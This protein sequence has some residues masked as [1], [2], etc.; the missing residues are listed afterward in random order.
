MSITVDM[1]RIT[2][3][4]TCARAPCGDRFGRN[5]SATAWCRALKLSDFAIS[6]R[7][8]YPAV[9]HGLVPVCDEVFPHRRKKRRP[10]RRLDVR[11][12]LAIDPN[13]CHLLDEFS[14][15]GTEGFSSFHIFLHTMSPL[16]PR[17]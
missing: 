8:L 10:P 1:R 12:F 9:R 13:S 6:L 7:D 14:S 3:R 15:P 17:R 4:L 16:I 5:T 2:L 11:E